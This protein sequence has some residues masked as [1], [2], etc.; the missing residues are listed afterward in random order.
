MTLLSDG[1]AVMLVFGFGL[2]MATGA[3]LVLR[4]FR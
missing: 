4:A 1:E 3:W 2:G